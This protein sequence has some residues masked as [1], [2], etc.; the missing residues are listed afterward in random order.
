MTDPDA[1]KYPITGVCTSSNYKVTWINGTYTIEKQEIP[2]PVPASKD[3]TGTTQIADVVASDMYNVIRNDGGVNVGKYPVTFILNAAYARNYKWAGTEE[4]YLTVDFEITRAQ[5]KFTTPFEMNWT[6]D[7]SDT[8]LGKNEPE[9]LFGT[10]VITFYY[11]QTFTRVAEESYILNSATPG[12]TFYVKVSVD[13]TDNYEYLEFT[14]EI[15]IV[16]DRAL[17]LNW[18]TFSA[19]Y[20]GQRHIPQAYVNIEGKKVYL[21]VTVDGAAIHA[22]EYVAT[23]EFEA[24]DGTNLTGYKLYEG[25]PS[26]DKELRFTIAPREVR[27]EIGD[28]RDRVYGTPTV[29]VDM[30]LSKNIY[31]TVVGG[32]KLNIKF[33]GT[34]NEVNGYVPVGSYAIVGSWDNSDYTVI[35]FGNWTGDEYV[36]AQTAGVYTVIPADISVKKSGSDWFDQ[37]NVIDKNQS[38]FI[39]LDERNADDTEYVNIGLKGDKSAKVTITYSFVYEYDDSKVMTDEMI[40]SFIVEGNHST[41]EILQAG[42]WVIYYRITE[43][44]H[45]VK[46]GQWIVRIRK[47]TEYIIVNFQ[48]AFTMEYGETVFG[49]DLITQ[50]IDDNGNSEYIELGEGVE[51]MTLLQLRRIAR[52]YAYED[53][54][55]NMGF[56]GGNTPAGKYSIRFMFREEYADEYADIEFKYSDSND[57]ADTNLDKYEVTRRKL[58]LEWGGLSYVYD[59]A[60]HIPEATLKGLVGGETVELTG[61]EL[62]VRNTLQLKNGDVLNVTVSLYQ[63]ANTSNAGAFILSAVIDNE[64]YELKT[65]SIVTVNITRRALEIVWSGTSFDYDGASHIPTATI[66]GFAGGAEIT[67]NDIVI[68]EIREI[69][70]ENGEVVKVRVTLISGADTVNGNYGLAVEIV[71]NENYELKTGSL[72][73][74]TITDNSKVSLPNWAIYVIVAAAVVAFFIILIIALKLK[75]RGKAVQVI[76]D[77]GFNDDYVNP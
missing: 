30:L 57:K 5:N 37:D 2:V 13:A 63:G 77:D 9:T 35:F 6:V 42:D 64:N 49:T 38:V 69:T 19:V 18:E 71:D 47:N 72:V 14:H 23:V 73:T 61:I 16:G 45:N 29:N 55:S 43:G 15:L 60:S 66:K 54:T 67:L 65:G 3:Y 28:V 70:L 34:F 32:D 27:V 4:Y 22:G 50:L 74:V 12:M 56:V 46:Y 26:A 1:G 58:S 40:K 62:G 39:T 10:P 59:G 20:D 36:D 24:L 33:T 25:S 8:S 44:N 21:K 53:V 17:A 41:P 76:D 7:T 51:G 68:G 48:K 52:A 11:D 31:G 75:K